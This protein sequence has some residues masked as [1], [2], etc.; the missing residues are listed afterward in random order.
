MHLKQETLN[1]IPG[2]SGLT[3]VQHS[4]AYIISL[5][6]YGTRLFDTAPYAITTILNQS[7]KPDRVILWL[8][9][10]DSETPEAFK[11]LKGKGLEIRFCEDIKSYKKLVPSLRDF[12]DDYIITADDDCYYPYDWFEQLLAQHRQDP[13]KIVCHRARAIQVDEQHHL[14]PYRLWPDFRSLDQSQQQARRI[15]PTGSSGVLY[16]PHCLS[17]GIFDEGT[18]MRLSPKSDETWTWAM[19]V[20]NTRYFGDVNPFVMVKDSNSSQLPTID[21]S[22][23]RNGNALFNYNEPGGKDQQ[24]K[25][26]A[27][28]LPEINIFLRSIYP[29][30]VA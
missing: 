9:Y 12:P 10:E 18:F 23:Q 22:Q 17:N 20:V 6:S 21:R 25:A 2:L 13:Q 14:L 4:P 28:A 27:D 3:D 8:A 26:V 11:A 7:V 5:T 16:P 15:F 19:S 29:T 30:V 1:Q 24:L